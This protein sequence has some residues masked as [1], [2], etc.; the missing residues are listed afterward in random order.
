[1]DELNGVDLET[2]ESKR[3]DIRN[4]MKELKCNIIGIK[5]LNWMIGLGK[6]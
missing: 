6:S 4:V 2:T 5:G 3:I 1:M